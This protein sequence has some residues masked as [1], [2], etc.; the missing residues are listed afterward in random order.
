MAIRFGIGRA[1]IRVDDEHQSEREY[2]IFPAVFRAEVCKGYSSQA[3]LR[4]LYERGYLKRERPNLTIKPRLPGFG[5]RQRFYCI[6]ETILA[7][8][9]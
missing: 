5:T 2:L 9:E 6:K 1:S 7:G 4:T 8:H 3:V